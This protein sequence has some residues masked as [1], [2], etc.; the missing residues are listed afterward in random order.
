M[1]AEVEHSKPAT[2]GSTA[3][4]DGVQIPK[5]LVGGREPASFA[6]SAELF[7]RLF[8]M[9]IVLDQ[10]CRLVQVRGWRLRVRGGE[11]RVEGHV[12]VTGSSVCKVSCRVSWGN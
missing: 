9:H 5:P 10:D 7:N 12:C 8:P 11:W 2:K 3:A 6:P 1:H 4:A